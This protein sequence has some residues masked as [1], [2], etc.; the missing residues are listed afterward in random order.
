[1]ATAS[2]PATV[3][4]RS[5]PAEPL[6]YQRADATDDEYIVTSTPTRDGPLATPIA[7]LRVADV[8]ALMEQFDHD[9]LAVVIRILTLANQVQDLARRVTDIDRVVSER[10]NGGAGE[11][12]IEW[13]RESLDG[14]L[15]REIL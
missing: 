14:L 10:L 15:N 5:M 11:R 7:T 3:H 2:P 6:Y 9:P 4:S 8:E 12:S 1:M 13:M